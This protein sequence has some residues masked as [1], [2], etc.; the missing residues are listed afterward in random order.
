M[1]RALQPL[2][3]GC[4]ERSIEVGDRRCE[5]VPMWCPTKADSVSR[6]ENTE[7]QHVYTS[8]YNQNGNL[9]LCRYLS[10]STRHWAAQDSDAIPAGLVHRHLVNLRGDGSDLIYTTAVQSAL[11][12]ISKHPLTADTPQASSLPHPP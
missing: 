5:V 3:K 11:Q 10:A 12:S 2:L 1:E 4:L 7:D 8:A 6:G 9:C